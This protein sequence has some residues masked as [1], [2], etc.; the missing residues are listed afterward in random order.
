MNF[1]NKKDETFKVHGGK[2]V[3]EVNSDA[4]NITWYAN[5][6]PTCS[7]EKCDF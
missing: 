1:E 7:P 4:S 6:L 3:F 2:L 5:G